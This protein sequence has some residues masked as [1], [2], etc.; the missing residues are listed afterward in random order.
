LVDMRRV[1]AVVVLMGMAVSSAA[2]H[3]GR[4][5]P[6]GS[7]PPQTIPSNPAIGRCVRT[8]GRLARKIGAPV[9]GY[10]IG[11]G[12]LYPVFD[13]SPAYRPDSSTSVIHYG[14][15]K[16]RGLDYVK[17]LWLVKPSHRTATIITGQRR[18]PTAPVEFVGAGSHL[19]IPGATSSTGFAG[20]GTTSSG[21][22]L[23]GHGCYTFHIH[24]QTRTR[25]VTF[26]AER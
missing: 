13:V 24:L 3:S 12:P 2:C 20:W 10:A 1:R 14:T 6:L 4:A 8:A 19:L 25:Q 9:G 15:V 7:G 16:V 18:S 21:V 22:L 5:N 11:T 23:P 26:Y 17:V